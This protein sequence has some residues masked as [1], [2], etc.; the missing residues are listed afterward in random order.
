MKRFLSIELTSQQTIAVVIT[1]ASAAL[2]AYVLGEAPIRR[3]VPSV[4]VLY[5]PLD[6]LGDRVKIVRRF[7]EHRV[8]HFTPRPDPQEIL[9]RHEED[10]LRFR[11]MEAERFQATTK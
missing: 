3:E 11:A 6:W 4:G 5:Q 2:V 8:R 10:V 1:L 9:R 7:R